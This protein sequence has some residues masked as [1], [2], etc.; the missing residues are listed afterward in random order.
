MCSS[1][2]FLVWTICV[3][4]CARIRFLSY[5]T[6]CRKSH[7]KKAENNLFQFCFSL[8]KRLV[9]VICGHFTTVVKS[10]KIEQNL[11]WNGQSHDAKTN[12]QNI[13]FLNERIP[14]NLK[15]RFNDCSI[16]LQILINN[17][18]PIN[19]VNTWH[20]GPWYAKLK[21]SVDDSN[22]IIGRNMCTI[23]HQFSIGKCIEKCKMLQK[24]HLYKTTTLSSLCFLTY[25]NNFMFFLSDKH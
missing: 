24:S 25:P 22:Q 9:F 8:R 17:Y 20:L 6:P 3:I 2:N 15:C 23:M 11:L 7:K 4:S 16:K 10:I 13:L 14:F 18:L 1:F 5:G 12:D 21:M 19:L